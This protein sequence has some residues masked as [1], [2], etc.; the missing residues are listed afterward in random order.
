MFLFQF[1]LLTLEVCLNEEEKY[2][3]HG[4]HMVGDLKIDEN[5]EG[6]GEDYHTEK[7]PHVGPEDY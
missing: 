5:F 7:H 3:Y 1:F 4:E 6:E 2:D